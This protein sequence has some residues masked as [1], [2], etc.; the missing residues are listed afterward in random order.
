MTSLSFQERTLIQT[1]LALDYS[2][3]AIAHFIHRSPATVSVEIHQV[4]P[5]NANVA[6]ELALNKCHLA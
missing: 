1:L 4:T 6:H 2:I 3:R 5:Y